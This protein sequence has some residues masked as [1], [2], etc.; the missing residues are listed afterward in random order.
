MVYREKNL[1]SSTVPLDLIK[2]KLR[3]SEILKSWIWCTAWKL[4]LKHRQ[5]ERVMFSPGCRQGLYSLLLYYVTGHPLRYRVLGR[6]NN[7]CCVGASSGKYSRVCN[8]LRCY[9]EVTLRTRNL[10]IGKNI[11]S[12]MQTSWMALFVK[13][14]FYTSWN[15]GPWSFRKENSFSKLSFKRKHNT[16]FTV[17]QLAT[18]YLSWCST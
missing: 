5:K 12:R 10:R 13:M 18:T 8:L 17:T 3:Y 2:R 11:H 6:M 1:F 7:H 14:L 9:Q 4:W 15:L 16:I